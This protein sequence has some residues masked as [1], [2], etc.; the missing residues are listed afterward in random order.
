MSRY[1][2]AFRAMA[3]GLGPGLCAGAML[4][5]RT[6]LRFDAPAHVPDMSARR[7]RIAEPVSPQFVEQVSTG[8]ITGMCFTSRT[9][10][11]VHGLTQI[12]ITGFGA[13]VLVAL[14]SRTLVFLGGLVAAS[15]HVRIV[16]LL[17]TNKNLLI[18]WL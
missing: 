16:R 10:K 11:T 3:V 7:T 8:S 2:G 18:V 15:I 4:A 6:P 13:G 9:H 17:E 1:R 5:R 14:F 12:R